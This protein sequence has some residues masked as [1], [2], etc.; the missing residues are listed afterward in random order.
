MYCGLKMRILLIIEVFYTH[1]SNK[2]VVKLCM[3]KE[4]SNQKGCKGSPAN[5]FWESCSNTKYTFIIFLVTESP[6]RCIK[7]K[8]LCPN[9][10][11]L[12][13][14]QVSNNFK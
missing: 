1:I 12:N 10:S 8:K 9:Y 13:E 4:L 7:K 6:K 11:K 3:L 2:A 5:V 14:R